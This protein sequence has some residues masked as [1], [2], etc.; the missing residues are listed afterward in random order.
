MA[1]LVQRVGSFYIVYMDDAS[2][3]WR[4][5]AEEFGMIRGDEPLSSTVI[6]EGFS[7]VN[8][9]G[10]TMTGTRVTGRSV[11]MVITEASVTGVVGRSSD[12]VS[13][14]NHFPSS[15]FKLGGKT[16]FGKYRTGN[17]PGQMVYDRNGTSFRVGVDAYPDVEAING[18]ASRLSEDNGHI[19]TP[20]IARYVYTAREMPKNMKAVGYFDLRNYLQLVRS[21]MS[22]LFIDRSGTDTDLALALPTGRK[23]GVR[24]V[25]SVGGRIDIEIFGHTGVMETGGA[26]NYR[27]MVV[28]T[29]EP[30]RIRE[31]R[32]PIQKVTFD[33]TTVFMTPIMS[34][35][36]AWESLQGGI[37]LL[38]P[39][40]K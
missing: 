32:F 2:T 39:P 22:R 25:S 6:R 34:L 21:D 12:L 18:L 20:V 28:L 10:E 37:D 19:F 29:L 5:V 30:L 1:R 15:S 16:F 27:P 36:G 11:D 40:G 23:L 3:G 14:L 7:M 17:S 4:K 9:Y 33:K 38:A 35:S 13:M 8:E 26:K 24:V 31:M